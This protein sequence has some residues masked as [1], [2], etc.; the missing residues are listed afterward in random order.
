MIL[1]QAEQSEAAVDLFRHKE[2]FSG[3]GVNVKRIIPDVQ[4][5]LGSIHRTWRIQ[6]LVLRLVG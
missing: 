6:A 2:A 3:K 4:H 5:A 1:R